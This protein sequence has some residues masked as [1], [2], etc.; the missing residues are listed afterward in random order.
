MHLTTWTPP[1]SMASR[2][3]T[4]CQIIIA[5]GLKGTDEAYVPIEGGEYIKEANIGRRSWTRTCSSR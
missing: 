4:G 5:D 2:F 1:T 3:S